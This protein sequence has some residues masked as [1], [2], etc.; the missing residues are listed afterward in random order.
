[1][2]TLTEWQSKLALGPDLPRPKEMLTRSAAE[3]RDFA[4]KLGAPIVMKASGLSHKSDH[5]G[6]RVGVLGI[7]V[8]LHWDRLAALGDGT[9]LVAEQLRGELELIL[10]G[11]RDKQ[12]GPVLS[13]G[14]G[15]I[16]AEVQPDVSFLLAP[17]VPGELEKAISRLRGAVLLNGHRGRRVVDRAGLSSILDAISR[18]LIEDERVL[19]VDC[20]PVI[21]TQGKPVVADA[22][23]VRRR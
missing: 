17:P 21:V 16:A 2:K 15:G 10:G 11:L 12:F 5:G 3:A 9:V 20:N 13:I 8:P 14:I 23:V 6:V 18:L 19:E 7:E 1:V 22:L 4:D